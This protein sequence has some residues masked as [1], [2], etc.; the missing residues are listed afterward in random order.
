M[1]LMLKWKTEGTTGFQE[2]IHIPGGEDAG[3][4]RW[5]Q[6]H[7]YVGVVAAA[8]HLHVHGSSAEALG[9]SRHHSRRRCHRDT[10]WDNGNSCYFFVGVFWASR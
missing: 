6:V 4:A 1:Y 5:S 3:A 7:T 8:S 10:P 2:S 9:Y